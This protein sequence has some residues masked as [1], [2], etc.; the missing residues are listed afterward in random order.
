MC[1]EYR[2]C[3]Q[4]LGNIG[5]VTHSILGFRSL[6][7]KQKFQVSH[8]IITIMHSAQNMW[9]FNKRSIDYYKK[10]YKM[11]KKQAKIK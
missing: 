8:K 2:G 4:S 9:L 7:R 11:I 6:R 3:L 10:V 5:Y 1:F